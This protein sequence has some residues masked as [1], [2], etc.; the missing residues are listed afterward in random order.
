MWGP[1]VKYSFFSL[2]ETMLKKYKNY[3]VTTSAKQSRDSIW[4]IGCSLP[5]LQMNKTQVQVLFKILY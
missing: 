4:L 5:V 3:F 1:S 2:S